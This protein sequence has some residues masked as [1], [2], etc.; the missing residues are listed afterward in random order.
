MQEPPEP[1]A[2]ALPSR[3]H[4]IH[5]IV[6]VSGPYQ[7]QPV[8]PHSETALKRARAVLEQRC[9][10][11]GTVREK[12]IVGFLREQRRTFEKRHELIE[13]GNVTRYVNV[14]RHAITQPR[15]VVGDARANSTSRLRQPP[16]LHVSLDELPSSRAQQM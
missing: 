15:A 5:A 14:M 11:I 3:A 8:R 7:W 12:E 10:L 16:M 13:Y 2:L 1:D 4:P 9:T 6:P